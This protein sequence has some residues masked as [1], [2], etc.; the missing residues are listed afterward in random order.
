MN[1]I[2]NENQLTIVKK[3][4]FDNPLIQNF[5]SL[6]DN[7]VR[8]C[9]NK[10]FHTFVHICEYDLNFTN[11]TNN[12]P[13]NFT[14]SDKSLG[15]YELNKKLTLSRQ[16]VFI[17]NHINKLT[18]KIHSN[19][20]YINIHCHLK[21]GASH[22]HRQFFIKLLKNRDYIQTHCNDLNNPFHYAC[23]Q[24]YKYKNQGILG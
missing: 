15:T 2:M 13:I 18:R 24:W 1:G 8:D 11:D 6:I 14:V 7:S 5:D 12:E 17:F 21:L 23:H 19:L 9:H 16:R 10:Y 4:E 3:Y 22:L 20:S